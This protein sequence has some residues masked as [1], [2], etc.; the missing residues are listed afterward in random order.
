MSAATILSEKAKG[1]QR[2]VEPPNEHLPP[3]EATTPEE[4]SRDL[5][6]RFT[7][8]ISDLI[9]KVSEKDAIRDVK[10]NVSYYIVIFTHY[11]YIVHYRYEKLGRSSKIAGYGL[12]IQGDCSQMEHYFSPG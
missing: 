11:S 12:F 3:V 5:V 6:I 2:A 9:L 8:G 1:K 7:E 4:L 10:N